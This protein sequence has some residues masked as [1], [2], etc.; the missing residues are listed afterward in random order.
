MLT[1]K[2]ELNMKLGYKDFW[3]E[4]NS[5]TLVD[6]K[7]W[8]KDISKSFL[9]KIPHKTHIGILLTE[10]GGFIE[11][12]VVQLK[13]KDYSRFFYEFVQH[14]LTWTRSFCRPSL[15]VLV[16]DF[17]FIEQPEELSGYEDYVR[18]DFDL[19]IEI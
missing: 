13:K 8:F 9:K 15:S 17:T 19:T 14:N 11:R 7:N 5:A 1:N 18:E 4:L 6:I 16:N 10:T 12:A 3:I 2:G